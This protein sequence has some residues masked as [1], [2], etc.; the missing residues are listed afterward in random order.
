[1]EGAF[2]RIFNTAIRRKSKPAIRRK[3]FAASG[4]RVSGNDFLNDDC[5]FDVSLKNK[6]VNIIAILI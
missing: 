1:M 4:S 6:E 2:E 3:V 5:E